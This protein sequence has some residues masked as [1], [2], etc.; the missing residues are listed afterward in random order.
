MTP[1]EGR[2]DDPQTHRYLY[3]DGT[4][5][6]GSRRALAAVWAIFIHT[7][8]VATFVQYIRVY[9]GPQSSV[10]T[11]PTDPPPAIQQQ[12]IIYECDEKGDPLRCWRDQCNGRWKPPSWM[13]PSYA[14]QNAALWHLQNFN[15]CVVAPD[16]I[17]PF[18]LTTV[19]A[20]LLL[21]S[22]LAPIAPI[23]WK[24]LRLL[25][26]FAKASPAVY[27]LWWRHSWTWVG[28][29][30][31]RYGW[32]LIIASW[33]YPKDAA[34]AYPTSATWISKP[35]LG[36]VFLIFWGASI[37]AVCLG[38]FSVTVANLLRAD[39]TIDT[40]RRKLSARAQQHSTTST[41]PSAGTTSTS[42]LPLGTNFFWVPL[43]SPSTDT[44][45]DS[46]A[47]AHG[48]VVSCAPE[49]QPY[50]STDRSWNLRVMLGL[51]PF[52]VHD[53]FTSW[54]M[55]KAWREELER[56]AHAIAADLPN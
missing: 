33:I 9:R 4:A 50:A 34:P 48:S 27:Q 30:W 10:R 54:P 6:T 26:T 14:A 7:L 12:R 47:G 40:E 56:R 25:W 35:N 41:H 8:L 37:S 22:A 44:R 39:L 29:P 24:H 46:H 38:L 32:A 49:E 31:T 15:A 3:F 52:E 17:Q 51:A 11:L 19:L 20:S 53:R 28:G 23:A 21:A 1:A 43:P 16:T 55:T 45:P 36:P 2:V 13:H 5:T 18:L 42:L